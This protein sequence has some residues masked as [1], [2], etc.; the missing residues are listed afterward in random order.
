MQQRIFLYS[1]LFLF[2]LKSTFSYSQIE[3]TSDVAKELGATII[4]KK[5]N[6]NK[7]LILN[8]EGGIF[9]G[10]KGGFVISENTTLTI[11]AKFLPFT[12]Q[13]IFFGNGKV[14]FSSG[15]VNQI[16]VT[17]FGATPNDETSD[18]DAIQKAMD[19]AIMSTSVS[20]VYF[21]PGEYCIDKP[22]LAMRRK[23][24]SNLTGVKKNY[25]FFNLTLLG[26]QLPFNNPK[27]KK[28]GVSVL[29]VD[30]EIPF[31]LGIQGARGVHIKNM[32]F[33]GYIS[34]KMGIEDLIY[35]TSNELYK[36]DRFAP[37]SAIVIDPFSIKK[38]EKGTY[39]GLEHL[40]DNK[41]NST[42]VLIE[43]TVIENFPTG[44]AISP[45]GTTQQGDSVAINHT[46]FYNLVHG[47]V[48][49]QTQSRNIV[50]DNCSFHRMKF[51]FNSDDFGEQQGILPEVNNIK[52]ADGVA[53]LFKA[54]G[55]VAYGHFRNVYAEALYGIG[56]SLLNK[57]P[58]NFDS[59]VF[60]FRPSEDPKKGYLNPCILK[61]D[62]ALFM[63]CTFTIGGNP[64]KIREPLLMNVKQVTYVNCYLDTNP[65]NIGN[66]LTKQNSSNLIDSSF[67]KIKI[68][69]SNWNNGNFNESKNTNITF[70]KESN[71][72]SFYSN[73][74]YKAGDYVF[75]LIKLDSE[76]FN[77]TSMYSAI[78]RV[79]QVKENRIYFTSNTLE[80]KNGFIKLV[81]R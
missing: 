11:D 46:R 2:I 26:H 38:P 61:A 33:D 47:I 35:K 53:W 13:Q 21:P 49:C 18:V 67:R 40:Y 64:K 55:N 43:N 24:N 10:N 41:T 77:G 3:I 16:D 71:N 29:K 19:A 59:C 65:I 42:R 25:S 78:G 81:L 27:D 48:I 14:L 73:K 63:G 76:P 22:L 20:V 7:P 58:L 79:S 39:K 62:N 74:S 57:Q 75:G 36:Q 72:F 54:N 15:S 8:D 50:V 9:V 17:W 32:V 52:V 51:A 45:N 28:G 30:K 23:S 56:Y 66:S 80:P 6:V 70:H 31:A 60:R 44:I 4:S 34:S 68:S 12:N 5:I 37:L 1:I 69:S